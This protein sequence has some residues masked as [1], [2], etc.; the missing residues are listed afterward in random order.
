MAMGRG[1]SATTEENKNTYPALLGFFCFFNNNSSSPRVEM[2]NNPRNTSLTPTCR[3]K[4]SHAS[5]RKLTSVVTS[6]FSNMM[7]DESAHTHLWETME[8]FH[9]QSSSDKRRG[10][11][12][13]QQ[14]DT[15]SSS[16]TTGREPQRK[17]A[18]KT[19]GNGKTTGRRKT[20]RNHSTM[21]KH[22]NNRDEGETLVKRWANPRHIIGSH[23]RGIEGER[24]QKSDTTER[25]VSRMTGS[26]IRQ[27]RRN[28]ATKLRKPFVTADFPPE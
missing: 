14:P 13:W 21:G 11:S 18:K 20:T 3:S 10:P 27:C 17:M 25:T 9:G 16:R 6:V 7:A 2:T 4:I 24:K 1:V 5:K 28:G 22:D 12:T 8:G 19:E 23:C 26:I 15:T